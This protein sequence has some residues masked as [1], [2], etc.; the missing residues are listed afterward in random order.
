MIFN[1]KPSK[2]GDSKL[3]VVVK[4]RFGRPVDVK[5]LHPQETKGLFD[6]I[7]DRLSKIKGEPTGFGGRNV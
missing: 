6:I 5:N 7:K 2:A 4:D 1:D 3:M